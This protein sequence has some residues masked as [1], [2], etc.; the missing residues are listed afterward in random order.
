MGACARRHGIHSE[1]AVHDVP[2]A[3]RRTRG[4]IRHVAGAHRTGIRAGLP[5]TRAAGQPICALGDRAA[6]GAEGDVVCLVM[7]NA[8]EYMAIWLGLSRVGVVVALVNTHLVG[9]SLAHAIRI[10]APRHIIV[11]A[12]LMATTAA[13]L[14]G[15]GDIPCSVHGGGAGTGKF[16]RIDQLHR[17]R[18]RRAASL[19]AKAIRPPSAITRSTSTRR[20]PRD[21][22]RPPA[23]AITA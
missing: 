9:D 3:D 14:V 1:E 15:L 22:R 21:S 5:R 18:R 19:S 4:P 23:S 16:P 2:R 7:R 13:A 6:A 11:G 12:D 17:R 10:V 8:P 20:G